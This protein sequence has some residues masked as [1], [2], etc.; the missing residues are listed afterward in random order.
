M[1]PLEQVPGGS[2]APATLLDASDDWQMSLGE[3]AALVGLLADVRPRVAIEIGTAEGGSLRRLAEWSG[4]V[5]SF[6]L[7][8][9]AAPA[10]A[11]ENVTLHT[12]DSHALLPALLGR[13][14]EEGTNVDFAVVDGDHS[15][16]GVEL[17]IR[18][19]LDSPAIGRT[20]IV[21]HDSINE[22][23]RRGME[24]VD[25]DAWPKVR[26][27]H[28]DAVAGFAFDAPLAGELWG[29]L[30][31]IVVDDRHPR[32]ASEP[33]RTA[34]YR[35][36]QPLVLGGIARSE[37]LTRLE[38]ALAAVEGSRTWRATEPLRAFKRRLLG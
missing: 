14:A 23:V 8:E 10:R 4:H 6:D 17:D 36:T 5:H 28:L 15:A 20:V 24:A 38:H 22:E 21:M 35:P 25:Y 12:G 13:L 30:A 3:R 26:F 16:A 32:A 18:Q 33:A 9:P 7:V 31:I 37:E 11:L 27:V 1:C 34:R 29:G 19:L 2:T